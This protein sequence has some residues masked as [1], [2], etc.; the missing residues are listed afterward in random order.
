M[1]ILPILQEND[2]EIAKVIRTV[3]EEF[4]VNRPGTV[5][6]DP[7]TDHLYE[8]FET[9]AKSA[10]WVVE[11]EGEIVG[12]AG[13]FPT[14][15]LEKNCVELVKLYVLQKYRGRGIGEE[16]IRMCLTEAKN[17]G[18]E[19]VYLETLPELHGA[20][21]LYEKLGFHQLEKPRGDS[22]HFACDLWMLKEI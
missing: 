2:S 11:I 19:E 17:L 7:T 1:T 3:L 13:I 18:Y 15:G 21:G 6:T 14:K 4:H 9:E 22:G 8:L 5:Y 12:G 16:L 20:I 10:Y